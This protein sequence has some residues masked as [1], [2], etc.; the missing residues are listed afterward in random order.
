[1]I[2][3][4][5]FAGRWAG[6]QCKK[7][8][9]N[10]EKIKVLINFIETE[11]RFCRTSVSD[12]I[13]SAEKQFACKELRF[14]SECADFGDNSFPDSWRQAVSRYPPRG[15]TRQDTELLSDFGARLGTT[16]VDGQVKICRLYTTLFDAR[17]NSAEGDLVK[18]GT[19]YRGLGA[20]CG[21]LAAVIAA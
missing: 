8:V 21:L 14:L 12:L 17:L 16:D 5:V 19:L 10:L 3:S 9:E 20:A 18:K 2:M 7:R 13:K 1:M 15:L 6:L 11:L 4:S